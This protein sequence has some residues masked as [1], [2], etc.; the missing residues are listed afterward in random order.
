MNAFPRRTAQPAVEPLT[1]AEARHHL[2]QDDLGADDTAY[3][4]RL[5]RAARQA[6]EERTERTMTTTPWRLQLDSFPDAIEL[7]QPPIIA[8]TSLQYRDADGATQ[9]LDPQDYVLDNAREPGWLVPAP[10]RSWPAVGEGINAVVVNYTAG[11]GATGADVP[12]PLRQWMLLAV[13]DMYDTR[14]GSGERAQVR[15]DF[16]DALLQPYRLLGV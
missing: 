9:T 2:R 5:I 13:A 16:A 10:G 7:L 4:T 8:I 3:I 6:C 15:H 12:E 1:V 14:R 11:Y